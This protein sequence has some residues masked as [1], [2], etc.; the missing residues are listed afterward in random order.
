MASKRRASD[1]GDT[2]DTI[3]KRSR[4]DVST[5]LSFGIEIEAFVVYHKSRRSW[6]TKG[7]QMNTEAHDT[8][9]DIERRLL[10]GSGLT[11]LEY[12]NEFDRSE[13]YKNNTSAWKMDEEFSLTRLT[14]EQIVQIVTSKQGELS[15]LAKF[16]PE[17]WLSGAIEFVSPKYEDIQTAREDL[18]KLVS[19]THTKTSFLLVNDDCGL[20]VHVGRVDD[21]TLPLRPLQCLAFITVIFEAE[22][23]RLHPSQRHNNVHIESTRKFFQQEVNNKLPIPVSQLVAT[24]NVQLMSVEDIRRNIF[25]RRD[26][27]SFM[28]LMGDHERN[29][30]VNFS[31]IGSDCDPPRTVEF[32]QHAGCIDPQVILHW[33]TFCDA[34]VRWAY[35]LAEDDECLPDIKSWEN[36]E[37]ISITRLLDSLNLPEP[38]RAF[39]L[40][41]IRITPNVTAHP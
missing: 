10:R 37:D 24:D 9:F 25:Q 34:L 32:R 17:T 27:S 21:E 16:S 19:H 4:T 15:I 14:T 1:N 2:V 6:P 29:Y 41:K 20:H 18:D 33:V 7:T 22:I 36:T 30:R 38:T 26:L 23:D 3:S 31:N 8:T 11:F 40:S 12:E 39:Y 13:E 35:Q 28:V 5:N